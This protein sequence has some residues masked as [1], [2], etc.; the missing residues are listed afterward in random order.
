MKKRYFSMNTKIKQRFTF[1]LLVFLATIL[2]TG[3][4]QP[5]INPTDQDDPDL[6]K[7]TETKK[8]EPIEKE[9]KPEASAP[10]STPIITTT[11]DPDALDGVIVRFAHPWGNI[12]LG[13][14][15]VIAT[16]FSSNNPWGIRVDV[17][18]MGSET[19]LVEALRSDLESGIKP[20]LVALHPYRL[21]EL[22]DA[23]SP[24]SLDAFL[25]HPDFGFNTE[26]IE[27]IPGAFVEQFIVDDTLIALPVAPQ[28]TV[29]FYNRTWAEE[30]GFSSP[31]ESVEEFRKQMC[32]ATMA[33]LDDDIRDN[34]G[35]GGFPRNFD[36]QVLASWYRA[37]GGQM[38]ET[39]SFSFNTP[40]GQEAF[41]FVK[42]LD[43][44]GCIWVPR[45]PDPYLYFADR[46]ALMYAGTLDQIHIQ[47]G[48]MEVSQK[49]DAWMVTSFPGQDHSFILFDGPGLMVTAEKPEEQLAA[50][51]FARHLL[52]PEVQDQLVR[53]LLTL[54]V[55]NTTRSLLADFE[56]I[57]PQWVQALS[58]MSVAEPLPI[59]NE[60]GISQWM[61]QDAIVRL[62]SLEG[63][64][65]SLILE[66]LDT[67]IDDL[68]VGVP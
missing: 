16:E 34:D 1:I 14:I 25:N 8:P 57:Y 45:R 59:S 42:S 62:M 66:E 32:A 23:V 67:M 19:V 43:A 18:G 13:V 37:F 11:V 54:P 68:N 63:D 40:V 50:W 26:E 44:E 55:R 61:L 48:W 51:L 49:G 29:M 58:L 12:D 24:Q 10:T 64:Q 27:D 35:T 30:L 21:S 28:A 7:A 20:D 56:E 41:G 65:T 6:P 52:T 2:I 4:A 22:D 15:N 36:P 39:G 38:P 9:D 60:W 47:S 3:C 5:E 31:P 46:Y 53:S 33:N 17:E